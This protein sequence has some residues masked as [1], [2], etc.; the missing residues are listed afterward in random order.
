MS[1][2]LEGKI[3]HETCWWERWIDESFRLAF[4]KDEG[5][6][7]LHSASFLTL[8]QWWEVMKIFLKIDT[9]YRS[10]IRKPYKKY[11][12]AY[13]CRTHAACLYVWNSMYSMFQIILKI[14]IRE[15]IQ[16]LVENQAWKR[17]S[18]SEI[19]AWKSRI[20]ESLAN[21]NHRVSKEIEA[22]LSD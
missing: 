5:P 18:R 13:V 16:S 12:H 10:N 15:T 1:D 7:L 14:C 4:L 21:Y 2:I 17:S 9:H 19:L 6:G 11:V 3:D 20:V 22:W 8:S